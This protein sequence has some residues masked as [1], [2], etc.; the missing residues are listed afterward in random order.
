MSIDKNFPTRKL[1]MFNKYNRTENVVF[2]K[3]WGGSLYHV[4]PCKS[5]SRQV[6]MRE[7]GT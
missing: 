6:K 4:R 2:E 1:D 3:A 5:E 7:L